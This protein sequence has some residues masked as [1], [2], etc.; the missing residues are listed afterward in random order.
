[1]SQNYLNVTLKI[2]SS[3]EMKKTNGEKYY[4]FSTNVQDLVYWGE[5]PPFDQGDLVACEKLKQRAHATHGQQYHST[6]YSKFTIQ[7]P[8]N[9]V[10][11]NPEIQS[12]PK[13]LLLKSEIETLTVSV[14]LVKNYQKVESSFL[15]KIETSQEQSSEKIKELYDYYWN[16][17]KVETQQKLKE[18]S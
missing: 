18:I 10:N 17:L 16:I 3:R 11:A 7:M 4:I 8:D 5:N 6:D 12:K 2:I 14:A 13:P 9:R 15:V 1:M